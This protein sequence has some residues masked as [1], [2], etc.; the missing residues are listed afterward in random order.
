M[1]TLDKIGIIVFGALGSIALIG[2][3]YNPT[4]AVIALMCLLMVIALYFDLKKERRL[5]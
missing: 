5:Q 2:I 3:F 4:Q 1:I